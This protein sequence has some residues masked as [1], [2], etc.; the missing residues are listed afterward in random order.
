MANI[1]LP[2]LIVT[3][4]AP[5]SP[6]AVPAPGSG[7]VDAAAAKVLGYLPAG[8]PIYRPSTVHGAGPLPRQAGYA[9]DFSTPAPGRAVLTFYANSL[10]ARGW[11]IVEQ[12]STLLRAEKG[13]SRATVSVSQTTSGRRFTIAVLRVGR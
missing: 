11:R 1:V 2:L 10:A 8:F 9:V 13:S 12:R 6:G 5:L 4:V 3:V 7:R